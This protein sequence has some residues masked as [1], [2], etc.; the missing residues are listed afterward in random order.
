MGADG[1]PA[2][3]VKAISGLLGSPISISVADT[4]CTSGGVS[5][6]EEVGLDEAGQWC[7]SVFHHSPPKSRKPVE[8]QP[9]DEELCVMP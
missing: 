8:T 3:K 7:C 2:S 4:G 9:R 1:P 6:D 5:Q